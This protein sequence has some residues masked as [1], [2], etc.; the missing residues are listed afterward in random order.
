MMHSL[1]YSLIWTERSFTDI[2]ETVHTSFDSSLLVGGVVTQTFK[3]I[4]TK[5]KKKI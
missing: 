2:E 4:W 1:K 5:K 3:F